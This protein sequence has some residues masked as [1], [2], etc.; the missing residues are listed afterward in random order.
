MQNVLAIRFNPV[1]P[2][3]VNSGLAREP[4][5]FGNQLKTNLSTEDLMGDEIGIE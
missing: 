1:P 5:G 2:R 4:Q 3:L